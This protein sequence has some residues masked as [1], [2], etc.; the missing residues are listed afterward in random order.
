MS[1]PLGTPLDVVLAGDD[2]VAR[3]VRALAAA[4]ARLAHVIARGPL[5]GALDET[6]SEAD[7]GA[8]AQTRL[9][10]I[11]DRLMHEAL[12]DAPVRWL[13]SEERADVEALT[14]GA[15]LAVALDPLD[16]SS[17][18]AVNA[19]LG[20]IFSIRP[21]HEDA[22]AT[23]LAPGREQVAA[24][25]VIYGPL[26]ALVLAIGRRVDVYVRDPDDG[27]FRLSEHAVRCPEDAREFAINASNR[28]HW[29]PALQSWFDERLAGKDGPAGRDFNMRW[30][31]SLVAEAYRILERG[32]IFLYPADA[33][34]GYAKGRLRL[35]YEAAP[36]AYLIEA[37]GG[38]ALV[39][40]G[41]RV[42]DAGAETL[43]ERTPLVFGSRAL[44]AEF[45]PRLA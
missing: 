34:A 12:A 25:F 15:P 35:V 10:L 38:S 6:V 11:A 1:P 3:T 39:G 43:H 23:F 5:E 4:C 42:L 30:I 8:D 21:A 2:P 45:A 17:N 16:G 40:D 7:G 22:G 18:I 44:V 36:I 33:R 32:G 14:P 41:T 27:S 19:P 24:G 37:A 31:A 26:T 13:A 29:A 9:D 28:R 20:T